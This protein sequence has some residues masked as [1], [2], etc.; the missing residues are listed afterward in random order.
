MNDYTPAPV[1]STPNHRIRRVVRMV[2]G[3]VFL[4]SFAATCCLSLMAPLFGTRT[5]PATWALGVAG[6][7]LLTAPMGWRAIARLFAG[8]PV[9]ALPFFRASPLMLGLAFALA[10]AYFALAPRFDAAQAAFALHI[11]TAMA[12]QAIGAAATLLLLC[13]LLAV[14]LILLLR[15]LGWGGDWLWRRMSAH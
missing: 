15:L 11:N 6:L 4:V 13:T 3:T 5:F 1:P 12:L 2:F 10:A 14:P 7:S 8:R 9:A